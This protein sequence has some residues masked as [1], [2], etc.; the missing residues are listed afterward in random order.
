[1]QETSAKASA[2]AT[3]RAAEGTAVTPMLC[4]TDVPAALRFYEKFGLETVSAIPGPDGAPVRLIL[5][6]GDTQIHV[7]PARALADEG[8][9]GRAI[10]RG[11]RGLGLILYCRVRD[12]DGR[13][14]QALAAGA[15]QIQAPRD[16]PWGDRVS[17]VLDPFGY[18]WCFASIPPRSA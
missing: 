8:D 6:H 4:V 17:R 3:P 10:E 1:M 13:H 5:R 11:P 12:V 15:R 18:D 7:A 16:E 2:A 9:H 14:R